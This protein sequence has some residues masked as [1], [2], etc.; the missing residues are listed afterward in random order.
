MSKVYDASNYVDD[1]F[2][3]NIPKTQAIFLYD[4]QKVINKKLCIVAKCPLC[5][6][7]HWVHKD[8]IINSHTQSTYCGRHRSFGKIRWVP[9]GAFDNATDIIVDYTHQKASESAANSGKRVV[10]IWGTC[11]ACHTSRWVRAHGLRSG[12]NT[13]YCMSCAKKRQTWPDPQP[14]VVHNGYRYIH[15]RIIRKRYTEEEITLITRHLSCHKNAYPE[16]RIVALL[17]YG[18]IFFTAD[19]ATVVRHINGNKGDNRPEN[20]TIGSQSDNV[21]DHATDRML[22]K[23]WQGIALNLTQIVRMLLMAR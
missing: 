9:E 10:F 20:L 3:C 14:Y 1:I 11:P 21:H 15:I 4:Q 23:K 18:P 19:S 2:L 22:A 16:H 17:K 7:H 6:A 12:S 5:S 8:N 13:T